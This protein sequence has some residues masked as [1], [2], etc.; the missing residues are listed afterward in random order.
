MNRFLKKN[1]L[2]LSF[3]VLGVVLVLLA[4]IFRPESIHYQISANESVKLVN[5]QSIQ[6][7]IKD[8][9]GKQIID[10]RST[11]LFAQ[12]HAE[13][14]INIPIRKLLDEESIE[15][16]DQ[17]LEDGKEVVLYGSDELEAVSPSLLLQQLGYKNVKQL[18]GRI[19][20]TGEFK[21]SE[22]SSTEV[23]VIDTA[24]MR[25][26]TDIKK[27]TEITP[28]KKKREAVIPVR[29]EVTSGGGC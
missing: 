29:Q 2:W 12:G 28:V 26:K 17:L 24:A 10:I 20:E 15:F 9:A 25:V 7:D 16:F 22:L 23:S 27:A 1:K 8:I 21:V 19:T 13:N 6:M 5:D 4:F 14:A 11:E 3:L 18:K